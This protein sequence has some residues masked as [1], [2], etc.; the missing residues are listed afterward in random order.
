MLDRVIFFTFFLV[1]F[2]LL[3]YTNNAGT[4]VLSDTQ[5][6]KEYLV[7][8]KALAHVHNRWLSEAQLIS[9]APEFFRKLKRINQV[10]CVI[11]LILRLNNRYLYAIM[12]LYFIPD[13]REQCRVDCT[14]SFAR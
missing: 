1:L 13:Q 6:Q 9:E 14:R 11:T 4:H 3:G 7:K 10:Q 12:I 5:G 2:F 8:Y